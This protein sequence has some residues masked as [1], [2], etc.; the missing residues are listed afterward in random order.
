MPRIVGYHLSV[1]FA[2]LCLAAGGLLYTFS[3]S[4]W[5]VFTARFLMGVFD[6]CAYVFTYSY[7][8]H[9]GN[10]MQQMKTSVKKLGTD[11]SDTKDS[12]SLFCN[13]DQTLKDKVFTVNL[14]MKSIM[15]PVAFGKDLYLPTVLISL[16]SLA[17]RISSGL[18]S[19][20]LALCLECL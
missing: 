15:Y 10:E 8:S 20:V 5:M 12:C 1:T 18:F 17:C 6:G 3:T 11:K 14:L 4:G 16:F 2:C 13:S 19:F 9:I 7:I